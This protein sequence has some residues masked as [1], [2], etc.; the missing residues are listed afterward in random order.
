MIISQHFYPEIG[1]AGNRMKEVFSLLSEKGYEVDILTANPTYPN[2]EIYED[3]KFWNDDE[4][5]K[6]YAQNITRIQVTSRKYATNIFNRLLYYL[7]ISLK[8]LLFI[9]KDRKQYD[10]LY[11]TSPPIFIGFIGVFAKFRYKN[12]KLLLDIRDLWPESLKGVNVFNHAVILSIFER[13]ETWMYRKADGI[14]INSKGF[15]DHIK[16]KLNNRKLRITFIPNSL[17]LKDISVSKNETN[18][19]KVI[20]TGNLG[21]AQDVELIKETAVGLAD[22]NIQ[23]SIIG[24]G[25][26]SGDLYNYVREQN[27]TN[28]KIFKASTK[29]ELFE[30]YNSH[31]VGLVTLIQADVFDTV[32]PGKIIDYMG[33]GLPMVA[34]VSGFSKKLIEELNVGYVSEHHN[35]DELVS[36]ILCLK[37]NYE[38][39][40]EK[41]H[42]CKKAVEQEFLWENNIEKLVG[43]IDELTI[44]S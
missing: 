25:M 26:R 10:V 14:I 6:K 44:A 27:L 19:F 37:D 41:A 34:A 1:S 3:K 38:D 33:C 13:L 18:E 11:V 4:F 42:N 20:Y 32:L 17:R 29:K 15:Y 40:Y 28:V 39:Y 30:I 7:E 35:A 12:S 36:K 2:R 24:Y 23:L 16:N 5:S 22:Y 31:S 9:I 21:L 43:L 8:M